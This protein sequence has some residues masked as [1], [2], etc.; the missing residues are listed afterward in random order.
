MPMYFKGVFMNITSGFKIV[1]ERYGVSSNEL[2]K[3]RGVS[4]R[5]INKA[6]GRCSIKKIDVIED[7][8]ASIG[9]PV[10]ELIEEAE[11]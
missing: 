1:M 11:K 8:C 9:C 6:I 3:R 5:A 2:A 4:N 10:S 7:Y